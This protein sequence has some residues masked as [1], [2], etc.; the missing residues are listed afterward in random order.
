LWKHV[1][2]CLLVHLGLEF[3]LVA[4]GFDSLRPPRARMTCCT[5][6]C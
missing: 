2:T 6:P 4:K 5:Y 1:A 3:E